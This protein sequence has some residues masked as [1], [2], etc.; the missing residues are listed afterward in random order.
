MR[1]VAEHEHKYVSARQ[2]ME[3]ISV[4]RKLASAC[5]AC[6]QNMLASTLNTYLL[7]LNSTRDMH[8]NRFKSQWLRI[9]FSHENDSC[10]YLTFDGHRIS[11]PPLA[12]LDN[13]VAKSQ[14]SNDENVQQN[15]TIIFTLLRVRFFHPFSRQFSVRHLLYYYL[16]TII[17]RLVR[18]QR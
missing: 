15:A 10:H 7:R 1:R 13:K 14:T 9:H 3:A 8:L 12:A 16:F 4:R 5:V 17:F 6:I 2:S 18:S 11:S